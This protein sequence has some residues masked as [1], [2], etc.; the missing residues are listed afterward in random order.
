MC[1]CPAARLQ[2]YSNVP[3]MFN[4]KTN[5]PVP[6]DQ[7]IRVAGI[8]SLTNDRPA[9]A[10][11]NNIEAEKDTNRII[12]VVRLMVVSTWFY[13]AGSSPFS[14][15][16][17]RGQGPFADSSNS[18]AVVKLLSKFKW[19]LT[20]PALNLFFPFADLL[21]IY[22]VGD[23]QDAAALGPRRSWKECSYWCQEPRFKLSLSNSLFSGGK[24]L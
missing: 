23:K 8:K 14:Y 21:G 15:L 9:S 13:P 2:L 6:V 17:S 7:W 3:I 24:S 5:T 11:S 20:L 22:C 4:Y 18:T 19:R 10:S 1:C 16:P 12:L